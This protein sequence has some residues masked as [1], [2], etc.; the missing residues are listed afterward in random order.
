MKSILDS[1]QPHFREPGDTGDRHF[2]CHCPS[3]ETI[4]ISLMGVQLAAVITASALVLICL[5][6]TAANEALKLEQPDSVG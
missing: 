4:M 3:L 5:A 2:V 1:S 6:A